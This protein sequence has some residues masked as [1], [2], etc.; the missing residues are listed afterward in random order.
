MSI[1]T[2]KLNLVIEKQTDLKLLTKNTYLKQGYLN[3][4]QQIHLPKMDTFEDLIVAESLYLLRIISG[5]KSVISKI[6]KKYK[7][8]D[9]IVN[10][11][12]TARTRD[13][14][15]FML[16]V[17]LFPILRRREDMI[18]ISPRK[19]ISFSSSLNGVYPLLFNVYFAWEK[20]VVFNVS[21]VYNKRGLSFLILNYYDPPLEGTK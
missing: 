9:I 1:I 12:T 2:R 16:S 7:E 6:K 15:F 5:K 4:T 10:L 18:S 19:S 11:T 14:S 20:R 3:T 13:Y 21:S 17:F 8:Y